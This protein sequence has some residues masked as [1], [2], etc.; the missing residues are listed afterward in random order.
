MRR[1][2]LLS[3]LRSAPGARWRGPLVP[4]A[5]EEVALVVAGA[6]AAGCGP[7]RLAGAAAAGCGPGRPAA[8]LAGAGVPGRLAA[9]RAGA[10]AAAGRLGAGRSS[11]AGRAEAATALGWG[12]TTGG[13]EEAPSLRTAPAIPPLEVRERLASSPLAAAVRK[14][15]NRRSA[16]ARSEAVEVMSLEAAA[17]APAIL[18]RGDGSERSAA[19]RWTLGENAAPSP[20]VSQ[21]RQCQQ[22]QQFQQCQQCQCQQ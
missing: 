20:S 16:R 12:A 4:Q 8:G 22:C 14:V 10:A 17:P 11:A 9:G 2:R 18:A 21:C 7:G 13:P 15:R 19:G 6:A 3:S 5:G 1:S